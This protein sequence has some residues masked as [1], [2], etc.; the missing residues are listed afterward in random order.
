MLPHFAAMILRPLLRLCA[1]A[2]VIGGAGCAD[3]GSAPAG[4]GSA[5]GG[6]G[7]RGGGGAAPVFVAKVQR[8]V[9]PL[10]IEAIGVVEPIKA[11]AVRS[12]ITGSLMK[13]DF[14]EGQDVK[15]GDLLLEI[16]PRPFQNTLAQARADQRKIGVQLESARAQVARYQQ[17]NAEAMVS[18]EQ[19]QQIQD[20]ERALTAQSLA[21]EAAV[22]NATLQLSYCSIRAPLDGRTGHLAVHE[23]DLV[24]ANDVG[25]LVTINQ[26]SPIYVTFG[27]PQQHLGAVTRYQAGGKLA[28][29]VTPPGI[30]EA[31]ERG[32]LTFMDNTVDPSTGTLKL[33]ATFANPGRR[34]WPGQ[35]ATVRLTLAEPE[36]F[37]VPSSAVQNS[38]TGQNVF[39]V[40]EDKTANPPTMIA[41]LR[42]ITVERSFE[43]ETVIA[44]GLAEG[45][46]VV[47]DGQLRVVSG[48]PV[49]IKSAEGA[50]GD[51][52]GGDRPKGKGKGKKKETE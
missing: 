43:N 3:K 36:V 46:I 38:Q 25:A 13:I 47:V 2:L 21:A 16:D 32:E 24:R 49:A 14:R 26:L 40:R 6:K 52:A 37:A 50:A 34:L 51:S 11:T 1:A 8:K 4:G 39:V 35:F 10:V 29:H 5:G 18:K 33:K 17:L 15:A 12:Q 42:P 27:V 30:A 48:R 45:E 31:A 7:G 19:F 44:K 41:E 28:V 20:N 9:V 23:G 22:A